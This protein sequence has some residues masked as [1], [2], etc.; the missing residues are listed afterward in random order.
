MAEVYRNVKLTEKEWAAIQRR[1]KKAKLSTHA[2]MR[3]VLLAASGQSD[4]VKD[5]SI[6]G[7]QAAYAERGDHD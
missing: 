5:C 6:A 1:A 7:L 4:I 2:W 3:L